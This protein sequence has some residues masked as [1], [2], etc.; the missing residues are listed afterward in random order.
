MQY[1]LCACAI[2]VRLVCAL[3]A[4]LLEDRIYDYQKSFLKVFKYDYI[5]ITSAIPQCHMAKSALSHL[6]YEVIL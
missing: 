2:F 5:I 3:K 1:K 4:V 6:K